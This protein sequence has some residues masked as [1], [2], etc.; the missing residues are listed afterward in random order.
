MTDGVH[1]IWKEEN[2]RKV[3]YFRVDPPAPPSITPLTDEEK[4]KVQKMVNFLINDYIG[5]CN[6]YKLKVY[7]CGIS[8]EEF[9]Q[10]MLQY[11][12]G[13]IDRQVNKLGW[14]ET[15]SQSCDPNDLIKE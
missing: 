4:A 1:E 10:L 3:K 7:N 5:L 12:N 11:V 14:E 13:A 6:R 9:G 2:G 8:A 15:T